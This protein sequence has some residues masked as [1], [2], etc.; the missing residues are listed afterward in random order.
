[1]MPPPDSL[2]ASLLGRDDIIFEIDNKSI[3]NRPDLWGHYGI[4][5]ELAA[6]YD[7]P[8]KP[9]PEFKEQLPAGISV[10]IE[11]GLPLRAIRG[12]EH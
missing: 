2:S 8:L 12:L 11:D 10:E 5:R 9:L 1:M 4:A 7:L 6:I 3:T